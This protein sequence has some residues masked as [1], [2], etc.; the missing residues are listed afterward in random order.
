MEIV[1]D[2]ENHIFGKGE[3]FVAT[4][5]EMNTAAPEGTPPRRISITIGGLP[6]TRKPY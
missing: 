4:S 6:K 2:Y 1:P 5:D 3:D